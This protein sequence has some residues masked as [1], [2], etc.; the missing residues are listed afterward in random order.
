MF[1]AVA[2]LNKQGICHYDLHKNNIL[3]DYKGRFRIIDFGA[4]FLGD[5]VEEK[6]KKKESKYAEYKTKPILYAF[7]AKWCGHC[8]HFGPTFAK[9]RQEYVDSNLLLTVNVDEERNRDLVELHGIEGFPTIQL[10]DGKKLHEYSGGRD[11]NNI[12]DFVNSTLK[13]KAIKG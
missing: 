8:Q 7:T 4:A 1:Q 10:F 2:L 3:V 11:I 5:E 9:L 13:V 6:P 12:R